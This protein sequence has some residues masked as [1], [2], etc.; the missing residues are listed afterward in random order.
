MDNVDPSDP[1]YLA[2]FASRD[3]ALDPEAFNAAV[4]RDENVDVDG[5]IAQTVNTAL[6][7]EAINVAK[8][9]HPDRSIAAMLK[10]IIEYYNDKEQPQNHI[11]ELD[12]ITMIHS[13][14]A[15]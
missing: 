9:K 13:Q 3:A 15:T 11:N 4:F 8:A 10:D 5:A 6:L 7:V 2:A 1:E 14:G 12:V